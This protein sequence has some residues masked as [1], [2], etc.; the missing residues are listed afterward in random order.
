MAVRCVNN[1]VPEIYYRVVGENREFQHHLI[2]FSFA[3]SAH[4]EN[5][6]FHRVEHLN[7]LFWRVA[8]RQVVSRSVIEQIPQQQQPV[9]PF[10]FIP[11]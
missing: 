7:D 4:A 8:L 9:C 6:I 3:V 2:D 1:A 10:R 11:F 5:F